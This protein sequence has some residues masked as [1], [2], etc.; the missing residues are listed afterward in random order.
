MAVAVAADAGVADAGVAVPFFPDKLGPTEG[1]VLA[2]KQGGTVKG[3]PDGTKVEVVLVTEMM[4]GSPMTGEAKVKYDG[5]K[6][7]LPPARVLYAGKYG[8][9]LHYSP[10]RKHV[11]SVPVWTCNDICQTDLW[12]VGVDGRRAHLGGGTVDYYDAWR[13]TRSR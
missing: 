6:V 9:T 7:T 13:A 11:V 4:V 3:I 1:I 2:E 12:L 5:K 8:L 10:D